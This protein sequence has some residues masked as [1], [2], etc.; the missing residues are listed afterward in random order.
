MATDRRRHLPSLIALGAYW[1]FLCPTA[2][3]NG[4][5]PSASQLLVD[6][7][8]ARHIVVGATYGLLETFDAGQQWSLIC[9]AGYGNTH[10]EDAALAVMNGTILAGLQEGLSVASDGRGCAF[11]W[12]G[13]PLQKVTVIDETVEKNSPNHALALAS[14][15][16]TVD[17]GFGFQNGLAESLDNGQSWQAAGAALPEDLEA[18]TVDVAASDSQRVYV[19]GISVASAQNGIIERS[20][21]RGASWT[22]SFIPDS[23]PGSLPFIAA[24]DP[25]NPDVVYVRITRQQELLLVTSDG[26]KTWNTIYSATSPILGFALAPDG[27]KVAVG[28]KAG[29]EVADT[30]SYAFQKT[31]GVA[32]TCL[33][34]GTAGLYACA[35]ESSDGFS[36][37]ISE[38]EGQHF[39]P[40]Y[41]LGNDC[42]L[43][44]PAQSSTATACG[45]LLCETAGDAGAARDAGPDAAALVD[46]G[47][48]VGG[49]ARGKAGCGCFL[50]RGD[51]GDAGAALALT[52]GLV[53]LHR[54]LRS[55]SPNRSRP[56]S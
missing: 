41:H 14:E 11:Q 10:S 9:E 3:A 47:L 48:P 16:A 36:V 24:I 35:P 53:W 8:D 49:A 39:E 25:S 34:W 23:P 1:L 18:L 33:T 20:D 31:S 55:R 52:A 29:I 6:R 32:A 17:G 50:A 19:S 15:A 12:A 42:T 13:G 21:D 56:S 7:S 51:G 4:R 38:D 28:S 46:A 22:R 5:F 37:G 54:R 43:D 2:F 27:R 30:S 26:A 40:L 44:C 45:P